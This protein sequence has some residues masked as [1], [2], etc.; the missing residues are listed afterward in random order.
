MKLYCYSKESCTEREFSAL[1]KNEI[2]NSHH[3]RQQ[4]E[5]TMPA[6]FPERLISWL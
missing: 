4:V 5:M 6:D 2:K 3:S 1:V